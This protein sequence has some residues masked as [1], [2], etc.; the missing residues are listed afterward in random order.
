MDIDD[1]LARFQRAEQVLEKT[2]P[3]GGYVPGNPVADHF[4]ENFED[5]VA[6]HENDLRLAGDAFIEALDPHPVVVD[7][8]MHNFA[9]VRLR[10]FRDPLPAGVLALI[11]RQLRTAR[12]AR[13]GSPPR[14]GCPP[15][16]GRLPQPGMS[17]LGVHFA[18]A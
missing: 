15:R 2:A 5:I 17:F 12:R 14:I 16:T 6:E 8:Q 13:A 4:M 3:I 1:L 9:D 11:W 10:L 7:G 18:N